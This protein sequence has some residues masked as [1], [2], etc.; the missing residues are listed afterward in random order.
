ML[1]QLGFKQ[2]FIIGPG[3]LGLKLGARLAAS[4]ASVRAMV[5]SEQAAQRVRAAGLTAVAGDLDD[6]WSLRRLDLSGEVLFYLAPPPREGVNDV[7]MRTF[8]NALKADRAPAGVVLISTTGVYGDCGGRWIDETAPLNPQADRARRRVD[9]ETTLRTWG[10]T[11][12]VPVV[13]LRVAGIYGPDRLPL[14]RLRRGEPV[15]RES[16]CS[17]TNRIHVDDL[18]E[19]CIAAAEKGADQ[20]VYNVSDGHP[21]TMTAYFKAVANAV[22]LPPPPEISMAE[23]HKRL[24]PGMMSYMSESRRLHNDRLRAELGVELQ[25]PDLVSGLAS[26]KKAPN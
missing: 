25:Y 21:G 11:H 26:V 12:K 5:R 2:V 16:E 22:G 10:R 23:A 6:I 3:Y 4:G 20:Q 13:I 24:S 18:V 8:V 19:I 1:S 7:R 9:A 15:V 17:Y 14:E